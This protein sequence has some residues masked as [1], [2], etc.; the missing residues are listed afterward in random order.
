MCYFL[1]IVLA[2]GLFCGLSLLFPPAGRLDSKA[3]DNAAS[4][5]IAQDTDG[6]ALSLSTPDPEKD[7]DITHVEQ[8]Y[9]STSV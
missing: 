8:V 9:R 2:I 1:N 4:G 6:P 5:M 7:G 3:W